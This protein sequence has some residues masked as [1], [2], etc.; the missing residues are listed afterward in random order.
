M[1]SIHSHGARVPGSSRAR[2][3]PS[4]RLQYLTGVGP[5]R[6]RLFERL[7]LLTL[8]DL[9]RHYPRS[10]LDARRFVP[11]RELKPGELVTV[12][13]KVR[14]AAALRTRAGRTDFMAAV[15]DGTGSVACYFFGQ[16]FLA[17]VLK[18]GAPVVL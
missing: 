16:P 2:L 18:R 9:M 3:E 17:R 6:A 15:E 4:S 8:E 13:G 1:T 12:V 11:I 7:G 10:Y 5:A 14:S